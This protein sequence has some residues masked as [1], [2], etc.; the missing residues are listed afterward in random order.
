M[1]APMTH[2]EPTSTLLTRKTVYDGKV[3]RLDVERV[4]LPGGH[5]TELEIIRHPGAACIVPFVDA[6]HVLLLRQYRH[7]VGL[8]LHELPAGTREDGED[9]ESCARRELEEE[10]GYR[11]GRLER[12]GSIVTTPGFTDERIDIFE[13]SDLEPGRAAT[14]DSEVLTVHR[15]PFREALAMV[16]EGRLVDAKSACALA[17]AHLRRR[18]P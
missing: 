4:S 10:T 16:V 12:L 11:A 5:V 6:D 2:D 13:A 15:V 17:L 1:M 7:A 3:L 14:D 9:L 18:E 8:Y